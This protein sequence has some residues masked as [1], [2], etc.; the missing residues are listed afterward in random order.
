M[1]TC[2]LGIEVLY[3]AEEKRG[4]LEFSRTNLSEEERETITNSTHPNQTRFT[5]L[6]RE[7][8]HHW[9]PYSKIVYAKKDIIFK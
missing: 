4:R 5:S 2:V 3:F 7:Y 6:E 8:P 1:R 9:A